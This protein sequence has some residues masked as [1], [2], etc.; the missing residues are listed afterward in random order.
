MSHDTA[1]G[2]WSLLAPSLSLSNVHGGNPSWFWVVCV[3]VF[4][5][6]GL[7]TFLLLCKQT[8][9]KW[10]EATPRGNTNSNTHLCTDCVFNWRPHGA[11]VSP[12]VRFYDTRSIFVAHSM[13]PCVCVCVLWSGD[14]VSSKRDEKRERKPQKSVFFSQVVSRPQHFGSLFFRKTAN[15]PTKNQICQ[16]ASFVRVQVCDI[17]TFLA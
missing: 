12:D 14:A 17:T 16:A 2:G 15:R 5:W 10:R 1:D 4:V 13:G 8:T 3:C 6:S 7:F 9:F 11:A